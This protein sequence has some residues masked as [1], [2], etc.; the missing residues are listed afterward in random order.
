MKSIKFSAKII[1]F[2]ALSILSIFGMKTF[3][4][5][6]SFNISPSTLTGKLYCYYVF[7]MVLNPGGIAYN[8][9]QST[10][11]FDSGN[12][13]LTHIS[14]NSPFTSYLWYSNSW[15][16]YKAYGNTPA[17]QSSTATAP[18]LTFRFRT[19]TNLTSTNLLLTDKNGSGII[20]NP[21]STDD[22]AVIWW[23][24][25]SKDIL[26]GI[27]NGTYTFVPLPCVVDN[28]PPVMIWNTPTNGATK[29]PS[30]YTISF[31]LYDWVWAWLVPGTLPMD[32]NDRSHYRY[33]G[34]NT[35]L[36][37]YQKAPTTVDNQ[38]W[39]N[40]GTISVT[41]TCPTCV[42]WSWPYTL[43]TSSLNITDRTG[44]TSTNK[45]TRN[46]KT[47]WYLVS[48][49][50]PAPYEI[51]KQVN[52]YISGS[53]NPNENWQTHLG[54]P[55]F[56]FNAPQ[57]P[58]ISRISPAWS[59]NISPTISPITFQF[60][61]DRAG[62]NTW[63]IKITIPQ[64]SSWTKFYTWY[65]YSGSD[66]TISLT[67]GA[68]GT[69]NSWSYQVSFVPKRTFTSNSLLHITW[70]V[71]D[72]A[73][74]LWTYNW[75]FTTSMNCADWWCSSIFQTTILWWTNFWV[76]SFTWS[77][78]VV[79]WTN[80]NSPYPYFT[81]INNDILMCWVPY[82]WTILTWNIWIYDTTGTQINGAVY[83]WDTIY[84]TW[85]DGLDFTISN[86]VI[87]IQ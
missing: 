84:I 12:I 38:E 74:N 24:I 43:T 61:D 4:A 70:T 62:I 6:P 17:G 63:S 75:S 3:A 23:F 39:V 73:G 47:R 2:S 49:P 76:F 36:S 31:V 58:T 81:G 40:S 48:F 29:V 72:L 77:L 60:N 32:T 68:P 87:I 35:T 86:G 34:L 52:V 85:M 14:I 82:T 71:Y 5:N 21:E 26:T 51:E 37:N 27:T 55:S 20:F 13:E 64:F 1:I 53:D 69:G 46:S 33:S 15:S 56:S 50:S 41:L 9:F 30:N 66:L 10:I 59:T 28:E 16:L 54:T 83:T 25:S 78:I 79:T 67:S 8:S 22:G 42:S 65:M 18:I 80:I 19:L 57:A 44:N 7:N 11:K 45:Y